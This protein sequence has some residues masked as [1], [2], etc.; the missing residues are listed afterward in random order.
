M[1]SMTPISVAVDKLFFSREECVHHLLQ[2]YVSLKAQP[3][4]LNIFGRFR[5]LQ[6]ILDL[7]VRLFVCKVRVISFDRRTYQTNR[8]MG[9][10][11][12]NLN[13]KKVFFPKNK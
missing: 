6:I 9:I 10:S 2:K 5:T 8:P 3:E 1:F 4:T 7:S 11:R 12:I 13:V